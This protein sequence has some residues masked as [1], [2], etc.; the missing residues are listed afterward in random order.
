MRLL[1]TGARG[2]LGAAIAR[3]F[4]P[5]AQVHPFDRLQL[6][7]CDER[8]VDAAIHAVG[9]DVIINCAAYNNV[10]AAEQE[11]GEALRVNTFGVIA[12]A[13][14]ARRQGAT[15]VHYSTDF[16]FDGETD[17]PYTEED[18]PNPRG[19]YAASKLLGDWFAAEAPRA[20][21]LRVESLFGHA[22]PGRARRGSLGTIIDRIRAGEEVPVFIDRTVSP[23][24][25]ADI[26][27]ATRALIERSIAPGLYHCVNSGRASWAAIA[28]EAARLLG[29]PLRMKP[30]TLES[31][32]LAAPRPR[33][34][35]LSTAKLAAAGIVMPPWQDALGRYL[36]GLVAG[37]G[38]PFKP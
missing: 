4:S 34:C 24:Y 19:L 10:D 3:E 5:V 28:E 7:V 33:Y 38:P 9:P 25:T 30:L 16:V 32:A 6:D 29:R 23:G 18:P 27:S 26:A 17:R 37:V 15:L 35:A 36:V 1:V 12:L 11:P 2:L 31:A 14:A 21:V 22:G 8:A 20:Y 13:A